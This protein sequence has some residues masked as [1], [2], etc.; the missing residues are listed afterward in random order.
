MEFVDGYPGKRAVIARRKGDRWYVAG[1]NG[2]KNPRTIRLDLSF[3]PDNASGTLIGDGK[4]KFSFS[5]RNV[6]LSS[7][8][9]KISMKGNGGFVM[10]LNGNK[11]H[12]Q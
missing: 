3:L 9:V 11:S 2:E 1:I 6:T 12:K 5:H 10:L 7:G 8:M 4:T